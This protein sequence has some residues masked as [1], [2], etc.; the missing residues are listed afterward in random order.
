MT[1]ELEPILEHEED[2]TYFVDL[3]EELEILE[4]R[5]ILKSRHIQQAELEIDGEEC[6]PEEQ[7]EEVGVVPATEL[8]EVNL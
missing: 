4:R 5:V 1:V 2:N 7:L 3:C 6:Q 8:A